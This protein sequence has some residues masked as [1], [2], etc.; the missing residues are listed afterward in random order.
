MNDKS[1]KGI[2]HCCHKE[3]WVRYKNIYHMGSEGLVVC[4]PCE[5]KIVKFVRDL[6]S[7]ATKNKLKQI[8]ENKHD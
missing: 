4:Q 7:K 6:R 1:E 2:C 8:R 3:K 5:N